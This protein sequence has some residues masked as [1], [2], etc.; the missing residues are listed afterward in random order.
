MDA[1]SEARKAPLGWA[2]VGAVMVVVGAAAFAAVVYIGN[3]RSHSAEHAMISLGLA[4]SVLVSAIAQ[5]MVIVGA[6]MVWRATR[7]RPD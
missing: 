1:G 6:W 7:R 3:S 5:G 2:L 4:G